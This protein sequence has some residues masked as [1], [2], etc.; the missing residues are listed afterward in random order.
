[1]PST[2]K[3]ILVYIVGSRLRNLKP[4]LQNAKCSMYTNTHRDIYT[5]TYTDI[6]TH[7]HTHTRITGHTPSQSSPETSGQVH[8]EH[9]VSFCL[10][11]QHRLPTPGSI[12]AVAQRSQTSLH[13]PGGRRETLQC[14]ECVQ[15]VQMWCNHA[16]Q[17]PELY[18]P[19]RSRSHTCSKFF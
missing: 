12:M 5:H 18:K 9:P 11:L 16:H 15:G 6:H 3:V 8:G 10:P 17:Q 4:Y 1:V 19:P 14:G 2:G 13:I 7:T